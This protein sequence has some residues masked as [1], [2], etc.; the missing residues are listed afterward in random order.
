MLMIS[1]VVTWSG[2][3][4]T[5]GEKSFLVVSTLELNLLYVGSVMICFTTWPPLLYF[6]KRTANRFMPSCVV[7]VDWLEFSL[8]C[9]PGSRVLLKQRNKTVAW[10]LRSHFTDNLRLMGCFPY[11]PAKHPTVGKDI[12]LWCEMGQ[13][14]VEGLHLGS[15]MLP[16]QHCNVS[17][18]RLVGDHF[19]QLH[20]S[21]KALLNKKVLWSPNSTPSTKWLPDVAQKDFCNNLDTYRVPQL[22]LLPLFYFLQE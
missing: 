21:V 20:S 2:I 3:T 7:A 10:I 16:W 13:Q 15:L 12:H 22:L 11:K 14:A 17:T 1:I 8:K 6:G 9:R 18:Q 5:A 4:V 19:L